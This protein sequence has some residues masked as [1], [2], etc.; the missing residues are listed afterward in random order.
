MDKQRFTL[1]EKG[2]VALLVVLLAVG[3]LIA[4]GVY[5]YSNP[6]GKTATKFVKNPQSYPTSASSS[7][8]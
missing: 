1:N 7:A 4:L 2:N 8:P 6:P 5:F 3:I